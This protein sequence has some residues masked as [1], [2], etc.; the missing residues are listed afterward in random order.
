MRR[1]SSRTRTAPSSQQGVPAQLVQHR[2]A[3]EQALTLRGDRPEPQLATFVAPVDDGAPP[4]PG[5]PMMVP[6]Q[7]L[8]ELIA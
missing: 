4:E 5:W 1:L 2:L 6:V 8:E 7:H 3:Q